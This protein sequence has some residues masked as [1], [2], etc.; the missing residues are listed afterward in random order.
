[1]NKQ[2]FELLRDPKYY[3]EHFC[4]IKTKSWIKPFILNEAQ[5]D[6]FNT[7]KKHNRVMIN[8]ARQIW[9]STAITWWMYHKTIMTPGTTS[10]L[11]W[12][13]SEL[14]A[15]LLEKV[16]M[17][18]R[19]TPDAIRP[20][21]QYNSKYEISF[22]KIESK[23]LILPSTENVWRWYTLNNVLCTE[24]PFWEKSEDKMQSLQGSIT[25]DWTLVIES[26]P[27]NIGDLFHQMWMA[28]NWYVKKQYGWWW[29]YT[30]EEVEIFKKTFNNPRRFA[31]EY[32]LSFASTGRPVFDADMI[33]KNRRF[34]LKVGDEVKQ[35]DGTTFTVYKDAKDIIYYQEP[36]KDGLYVIGGDVA[37]GIEEWDYSV[38][39]VW[40][41][42]NGEEVAFFRWH[43]APD[44]FAKIL[45]KLWRKYNDALEVIEVNNHWL[46]TL[47]VLKQLLYPNLYFRP[48]KYEVVGQPISDKIWWRTTK[49]TRPLLIDDFAQAL[50]D[51]LITIHTKE[52]LDEMTVFVYDKSNNAI[53]LPGYHDD[54]IF[55]AGIGFQWFK[56]LF[57]GKL[58]QIDY[59]N[60]LPMSWWY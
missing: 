29:L 23:I 17:F 37:E 5:K 21:V 7:L 59:H 40:N 4:K 58:E 47:T 48:A 55:S 45:D 19:S 33:K 60:V 50:R 39:T 46:T 57:N 53:S 49:L 16:K 9:F 3:L 34:E 35:K 41:R 54:C 51:W 14:T 2:A 10:A 38:A 25:P 11:I 6:L 20:T 32:E 42:M 27:G 12:Y 18:M 43:V 36:I 22:P 15:E 44:E 56:I 13:N 26:T 1:M 52:L 30:K 8:K 28:D 24:L 31:Q